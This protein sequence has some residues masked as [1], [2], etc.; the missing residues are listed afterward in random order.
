MPYERKHIEGGDEKSRKSE[1]LTAGYAIIALLKG[2]YSADID[3][4]AGGK[5]K[6]EVTHNENPT[7]EEAIDVAHKLSEHWTE[8]MMAYN[9]SPDYRD[10]QL[11]IDVGHD[12]AM[13]PEVLISYLATVPDKRTPL[14]EVMEK[15]MKE[16]W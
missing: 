2:D 16:Q 11:G 6:I 12:M 15:W 14:K 7:V 9:N 13:A 3:I 4:P 10:H 8:V 5:K 1:A